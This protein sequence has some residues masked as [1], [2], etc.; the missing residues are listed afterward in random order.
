MLDD[1]VEVVGNR[2][3]RRRKMD[4]AGVAGPTGQHRQLRASRY[5]HTAVYKGCEVEL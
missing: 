4:G 5:L 1:E 3:I 2:E